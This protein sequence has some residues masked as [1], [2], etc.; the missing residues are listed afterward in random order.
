MSDPQPAE[1]RPT[2]EPKPIDVTSLVGYAD[3]DEPGELR[4][5]S[6]RRRIALG[7][8][9]ALA[10]LA[11]AVFATTGWR[12]IRQKDATLSTP[13]RIAG[14]ERDDREAAVATAEYLRNA[15]AADVDLNDSVGAVYADPANA[16]RSVLVFGGTALLW[17]PEENLDKA[18]DLLSDE[19]GKVEGIRSISPGDLGGVAKCGAT[20]SQDGDMAVCGWAD[21]GS[22]AIVMFPGRQV[23]ES[24]QLLVSIRQ[25]IQRR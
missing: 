16:G 5:P 17:R 1:S 19:S 18:F 11:G 15:L 3:E 20:G 14:L 10:V 7:A 12:V 21:H 9:L 22:I 23:D 2:T 4:P 25:E 24:G 13:D 8:L 6:R